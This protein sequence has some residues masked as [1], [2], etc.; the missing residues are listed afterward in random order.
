MFLPVV[1]NYLFDHLV[2]FRPL[3]FPSMV[4]LDVTARL[5][6]SLPPYR[7]ILLEKGDYM[8]SE[9]TWTV[10]YADAVLLRN[11]HALESLSRPHHRYSHRHGFQD[12]ILH[13]AC[14]AKWGDSNRRLC[15]VRS[16]VWDRTSHHHVGLF[17]QILYM[18]T[19]VA[20]DDVEPSLRYCS[21]HR[22]ENILA[23]MS[24]SIHIGK[25]IHS[26]CE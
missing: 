16:N 7:R 14:E 23:K 22:R 25:I 20:A 6:A 1:S 19:W 15:Y 26:T 5:Q 2:Q 12:L 11:C 21:A 3:I 13:A 10:S 4:D 24:D 17:S 18:L 8:L 9:G